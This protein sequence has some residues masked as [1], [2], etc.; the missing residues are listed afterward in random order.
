LVKAYPASLQLRSA[1]A[2]LA[3]QAADQPTARQQFVE[4][5]TRIDP[6]VWEDRHQFIEARRWAFTE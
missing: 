1:F 4:L 5:G 2:Y 6:G 3:W